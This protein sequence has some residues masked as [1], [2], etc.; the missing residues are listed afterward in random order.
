MKFKIERKI[1][2]EG[3]AKVGKAITGKLG[4]PILDG[5]YIKASNNQLTLIGSDGDTTIKTTVAA[6][7]SDY[8]KA[9]EDTAQQIAEYKRTAEQNY[10][11]LQSTVQTLDGKSLRISLSSCKQQ[12]DLKQDN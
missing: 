8:S 9:E 5:M 3:I 11:G 4:N 10:S 2:Q 6:N 12:K 1:M 7:V